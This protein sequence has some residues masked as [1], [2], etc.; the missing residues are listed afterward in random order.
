MERELLLLGLLNYQDMHG[1]QIIESIKLHFENNIQ[2]TMP[3]AYR[4]LEKMEEK[5]WVT[6]H[7]E[8]VGNR[9]IRKVYAITAAGQKELDRMVDASLAHYQP[10]LS[11]NLVALSFLDRLPAPHALELL[12]QQRAEVQRLY[13]Q[14]QNQLQQFQ[15]ETGEGFSTHTLSAEN[16]LLHLE[17]EIDWLEQLMQKLQEHQPV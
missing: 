2:L 13:K 11:T 14:A 12:Q 4:L 1:Y 8:Q 15:Q 5:G 3:T 17:V 7:D 16:Q 10:Q 9:P 6:S